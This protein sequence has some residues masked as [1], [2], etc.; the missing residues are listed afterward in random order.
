MNKQKRKDIAEYIDRCNELLEDIESTMMDEQESLDNL[1][2]NLQDSE[3]ASK[4][5]EYIDSL[6]CACDYLREV[7]DNLQDTL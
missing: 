6:E 7:I 3:M 2:E 5:E 1:P 4:M